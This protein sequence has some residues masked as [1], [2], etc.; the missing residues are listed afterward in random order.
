MS[1]WSIRKYDVFISFR[2][3]DVR[4]NFISHLGSAL[5]RGNIEAFVDANLEKGDEVWP[6][7]CEAIH[8]SHL[9]IVVF[10][11]NYADSKW[12]LKELVEILH[13][14]KIQGLAVIPVFYQVDPSHIRKYSGTYG[15]AIAKHETYFGDT[16]NESIQ[17]WKAAL[18]E[19]ANICGW[20]SCSHDYKNESHLIEKIVQD[21]SQ[22]LSLRSPVQ[23]KVEDLVEIEKHCDEVKQLLS[24]NQ[25]HQFQENVQIIGIWGMGGLGKTTIAKALFSQMFPQYDAVCFLANV[26]E[27]S[28]RFGLNSLR[29]VL[30]S[31]LLQVEHKYDPEESTM[32]R[33]SNK[34][35]LIVLDDV[36]SLDQLDVLCRQQCK[37]AGPNSKLI[38]TTRDRHLLR[39]IVD[40][41]EIYDVKPW[42]SAKSLELFCLHA[43]K[44]R[45]PKK[46]YEKLSERAVEYAGGVP[47]ALEVLGS[48]LC[49][50]STEFWVSELRK[51]DKCLNLRIQNVLQVS[52][53]G[54]DNLEKNIFL[55]IAFFFKG[56]DKD[57]VIRILDACGFC[58]TSG[59]QVLE[60]KALITIS[61]S[62]TIQMHDLIQEMGLYIVR[63]GCK[64]PNKRTRLRDIEEVSDVLENN[65]GS[66]VV[67]GIQLDLSQI[68]N[69]R[70]KADT[71]NM[72]TNLRFLKLYVPS[73]KKSGNVHHCGVFS[74]LSAKLR[75]LEWNGCFLKSLP[76]TFCAK[77]LVEICMPHSHVTELWQGV[78]DVANL[79]RIDLSE[80]KHLKNL[81]DLSKA[82]RLKWVNLFGC[83]SL[84]DIH[85]SVF[86]F[87]TLETLI[88]D[89]CKKLKSLKSE[90]HLTSLENISVNLCTSLKEF[91]VSSDSIT[92]LDLSSTG[93]EM[94]DS[95]SFR[96]LR[97][98]KALSVYRLR[99]APV[100]LFYLKDLAELRI[101]NCRLAISKH[102]LHSLFGRSKSLQVLHLKYCCN[103]FELPNNISGLYK[104]HELRLD[105]SNVKTLP[106]S[107]K[108]LFSLRILS[109]ENCRK[110]G[111]LTELPPFVTEL[112]AMN[113]RSLRTVSTLRESY[114]IFGVKSRF[115]LF[116]NCV[117]LDEPS[118]H[119]IMEAAHSE[120]KFAASEINYKFVKVCFPGSRVPGHF[121]YRTTDSS[122]TIDLPPSRPD[123]V[124][125]CLCVVLSHSWGMKNLGAKIWCQCYVANGRRLGPA[126]TW[127]DEV[128][129][130]LNS[131]HVFIW[132]DRNHSD[133]ILEIYDTGERRVSF[134]FF[135]TNAIGQRLT[136]GTLE[137]GVFLIFG[138][139]NH[140]YHT[141][142]NEFFVSLMAKHAGLIFKSFIRLDKND[143][144][145]INNQ[146]RD[147]TEDGSCS[148]DC[149]FDVLR[150]LRRLISI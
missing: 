33:L 69:V 18:T 132:Y 52:Y 127:Y 21:V 81:P 39:G 61:Y 101:F 48:N 148:C 1:S 140:L 46:G 93:I 139:K 147:L 77:M 29:G 4:R 20:D 142:V 89:G 63:G 136:I 91:S 131:D 120:T 68:E 99:R 23:L 88:L 145:D 28:E 59:V 126:T 22:K 12:C 27:E 55:D 102:L 58:A 47:L 34:K 45:L 104:L 11:E 146:E 8:D 95:P 86:S 94:L 141:L 149:L 7:L 19:A 108:D 26:R 17:D 121:E 115:I 106:A 40:E 122:I 66:D 67:E 51:L 103:L 96:R 137:C 50:R 118:L 35:V 80:C 5:H 84:C 42:G 49:C 24:K 97:N 87:D 73:G 134:E 62:G 82:S 75:Y 116:K 6:S 31:K 130:G 57:D 56:E 133:R 13:C 54:L 15:E 143:C 100:D 70:W 105:G 76:V 36:D 124:G 113:C 25:K 78:Q 135:V 37:Y 119:Y 32:K 109:V 60:D 41:N 110:L 123:F 38:I 30:L 44:Q 14:R 114:G 128:V 65:K 53:D 64:D 10:S 71:F 85:P 98:L 74:K 138:Q 92:S 2:G 107:I 144:I 3:E 129:T 90:K 111:S 79:V 125:L 43:F 117:A 16:D 112:N 72:M 83:E 9:A 150:Y